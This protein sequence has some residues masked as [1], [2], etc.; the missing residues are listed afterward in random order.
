[1]IA[2]RLVHCG[3][4]SGA[5]TEPKNITSDVRQS[6]QKG[7]C[8]RFKELWSVLTFD[9]MEIQEHLEHLDCQVFLKVRC[10]TV[11][12]FQKNTS[13]QSERVLAVLVLD[14]TGKLGQVI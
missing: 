8:K 9:T 2:S 4:M 6:Q 10:S 5:I 1:M 12:H 7:G 11:G 13:V 3:L 14:A